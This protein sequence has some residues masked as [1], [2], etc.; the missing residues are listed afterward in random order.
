MI[1]HMINGFFS[2]FLL[3]KKQLQVTLFS[4]K[5]FKSSQTKLWDLHKFHPGAGL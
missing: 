4:D 2:F 1:L 5:K 3:L